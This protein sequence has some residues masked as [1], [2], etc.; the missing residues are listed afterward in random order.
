MKK[1]RTKSGKVE[2]KL[3]G[4]NA[5]V[6]KSEKVQIAMAGGAN[7]ISD[8]QAILGTPGKK[9]N[10]KG[11]GAKHL[12]SFQFAEGPD[13]YSGEGYSTPDDPGQGMD[14]AGMGGFTMEGVSKDDYGFGGT[15]GGRSR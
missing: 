7:T 9:N 5:T 13:E 10:L 12:V 2:E 15:P 11:Q 1:Y 3:P 8:V 14:D 4:V 6:S